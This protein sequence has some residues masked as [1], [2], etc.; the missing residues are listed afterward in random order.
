MLI[1]KGSCLFVIKAGAFS[2]HNSVHFGSVSE[3]VPKCDLKRSQICPIWGNVTNI[4]PKSD[5][6]DPN[7]SL[8]TTHT[9]TR[10]GPVRHTYSVIIVSCVSS[11]YA[12]GAH[13]QAFY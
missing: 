7:I 4:E 10:R 12:I 11:C 8:H 6:P 9:D 1:P 2:A 5:I 13:S 3:N